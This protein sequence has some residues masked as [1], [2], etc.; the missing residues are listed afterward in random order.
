MS[1]STLPMHNEY[2][3]WLSPIIASSWQQRSTAQWI[4]YRVKESSATG[5]KTHIHEGEKKKKCYRSSAAW[6]FAWVVNVKTENSLRTSSLPAL[7]GES[8]GAVFLTV[9]TRTRGRDEIGFELFAADFISLPVEGTLPEA[10]QVINIIKVYLPMESIT[11]DGFPIDKQKWNVPIC[12]WKWWESQLSLMH[13][14]SG[15][16]QVTCRDLN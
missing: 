13:L 5:N 16:L 6:F 2:A 3:P 1:S 10:E 7:V 12:A 8:L 15:A 9:Q 11:S 4:V 14:V